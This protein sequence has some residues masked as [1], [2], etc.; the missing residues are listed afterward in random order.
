MNDAILTRTLPDGRV[1]PVRHFVREYR[2]RLVHPTET[3]VG[4]V[5]C[6][7]PY[8][9][10]FTPLTLVEP[11]REAASLDS[12]IGLDPN[13]VEQLVK[14]DQPGVRVAWAVNDPAPVAIDGD[15][16][17]PAPLL[18]V[19]SGLTVKD[20]DAGCTRVAEVNPVA[21]R[22]A[23]GPKTGVHVRVVSRWDPDEHTSDSEPEHPAIDRLVAA[24]QRLRVE[25]YA[26]DNADA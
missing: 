3:H 22:G 9:L 26:V 15:T 7:D 18:V 8:H 2:T 1:L 19:E 23:G 16:Q 20:A 5:I 10:W 21:E 12:Y 14:L 24:G 6:G 11:Y 13:G 17:K 4:D 25:I